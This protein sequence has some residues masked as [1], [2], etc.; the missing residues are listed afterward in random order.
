ML[1]P[2]QQTRRARVRAASKRL[3]RVAPL[4]S[5][6]LTSLL[7]TLGSWPSITATQEF[8]VPRSMPIVF[9]AAGVLDCPPAEDAQRRSHGADLRT[10]KH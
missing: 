8:V 10:S 1:L 9:V 4:R 3:E 5:A 2:V 6:A 7:R